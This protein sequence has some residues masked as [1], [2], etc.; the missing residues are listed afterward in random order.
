M[1]MDNFTTLIQD[2]G[3]EV[4]VL[5]VFALEILVKVLNFF[6]AFRVRVIVS[7]KRNKSYLA[8]ILYFCV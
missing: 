4:N 8:N 7:L 5:G 6:F 3:D 2:V 1:S